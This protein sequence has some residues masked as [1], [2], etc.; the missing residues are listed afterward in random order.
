M[1]LSSVFLFVLPLVSAAVGKQPRCLQSGDEVPI[2]DALSKGQCS[3]LLQRIADTQVASSRW[4][5]CVRDQRI[6]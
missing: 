6:D 4:S 3:S 5:R 2:N 1:L